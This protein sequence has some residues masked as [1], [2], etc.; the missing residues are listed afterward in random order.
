MT[1]LVVLLLQPPLLMTYFN[2]KLLSNRIVV[3]IRLDT[4]TIIHDLC[5]WLQSV[6][7]HLKRILLPEEVSDLL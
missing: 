6:A 5:L 3:L 2:K 1:A 7:G 4:C